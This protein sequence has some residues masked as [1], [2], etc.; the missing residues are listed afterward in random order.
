MNKLWQGIKDFQWDLHEKSLEPYNNLFIKIWILIS[1]LY[2]FNAFLN[3]KQFY[4]V[5]MIKPEQ[6]KL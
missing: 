6:I 2:K 3:L 4:L 1:D 5:L